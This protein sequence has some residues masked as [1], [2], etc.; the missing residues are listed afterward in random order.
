M[1]VKY[2][3]WIN[4]AHPKTQLHLLYQGSG[5]YTDSVTFTV[6]A[7]GTSGPRFVLVHRSH[8]MATTNKWDFLWGNITV[9]GTRILIYV[10]SHA[11]HRYLSDLNSCQQTAHE[12]NNPSTPASHC[13]TPLQ[14][15]LFIRG[16]ISMVNE[17]G[18]WKQTPPS[19][20]SYFTFYVKLSR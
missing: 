14:S 20:S 9:V 15:T 13:T 2:S 17:L 16:R 1:S 5:D 10:R 4:P 7:K 8:D 3:S 18:C 6:S 12:P 19:F 11:S